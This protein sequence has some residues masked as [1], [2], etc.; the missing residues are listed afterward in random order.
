MA[1]LRAQV[2][3]LAVFLTLGV[4]A[5]D[6]FVFMDAWRQSGNLSSKR[7]L[8]QR[9][10]YTY[11]RS[12]ISVLTT[13]LTTA[14]T[15]LFLATTPIMPIASFGVFAAFAIFFNWARHQRLTRTSP[16]AHSIRCSVPTDRTVAP[17]VL[18]PDTCLL[19]S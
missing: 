12:F 11:E 16:P 14:I 19:R 18:L 15:F 1:F 9:M 8:A 2:H 3:N 5:D 7:T 13:S 17:C 4:G 6:V 10:E